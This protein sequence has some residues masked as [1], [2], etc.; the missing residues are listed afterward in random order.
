MRPPR[1]AGIRSTA[2]LAGA[3]RCHRW[4][5]CRP[6]RAST[7]TGGTFSPRDKRIGARRRNTS[8]KPP[9]CLRPLQRATEDDI[10]SFVDCPMNA[11]SATKPRMMPIKNLAKNGP[12]SVLKPRCTTKNVPMA[13]SATSRRFCCKTALAQP[14]RHRDQRRKTLILGGPKFGLTAK[15]NRTLN[16]TG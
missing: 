16:A 1:V 5:C 9:I 12:V 2:A 6:Q 11:N 7:P 13:R 8:F 3:S 4:S 15:P 10:T 14:A